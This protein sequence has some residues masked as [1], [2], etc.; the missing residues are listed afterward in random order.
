MNL[1][2][3]RLTAIMLLLLAT[4]PVSIGI[5]LDTS[6]LIL[7]AHQRQELEHGHLVTIQVKRDDLQ[8]TRKNVEALINGKLF[9]V[10]K[11]IQE[12]G[13]YI[14]TGLFDGDEDK[15]VAALE[16]GGTNSPDNAV[17]HCRTIDFFS[18]FLQCRQF[19]QSAI[20]PFFNNQTIYSLFQ[21]TRPEQPALLVDVPPP[22]TL[23]SFIL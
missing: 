21:L 14:I 12:D 7:Q 3:R 6:R 10:D 9:D 11:V 5:F 2:Y 4:S 8:W 19:L 18:I 13:Y 1:K 17:Q 20:T 15:L 16:N 22:E 23:W